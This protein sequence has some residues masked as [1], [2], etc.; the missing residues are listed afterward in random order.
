MYTELLIQYPVHCKCLRNNRPYY[1][2]FFI[3][4][5][6]IVDLI[7]ERLCFQRITLPPLL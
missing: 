5:N 7:A 4:I 2:L 6:N 1:V 3:S